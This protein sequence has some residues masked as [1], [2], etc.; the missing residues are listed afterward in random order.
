MVG[1]DL[2]AYGEPQDTRENSLDVSTHNPAQI[3]GADV[4]Y[5][6]PLFQR[7]YVWTKK[8]QWQPLWEDVQA[9]ADRIYI[10]GPPA[11]GAVPVPPHFLGAI[12]LEQ[13][14]IPG[15][16]IATFGVVDGQQRLTTLQLLLDAAQ[17][18][19]EQHGRP[20]DAKA[21]RALVLNDPDIA[22][23]PDDIFKVWPTDRDQAAFR[24]AMKNGESIPPELRDS[25]I[26]AAHAYFVG[27]IDKWAGSTGDP[28]KCKNRLNALVRALREHLQVVRID[29]APEDNAQV[30]FETLNHRGSPLLA[31]DLVKNLLFQ[32]AQNE[33]AD[34]SDLYQ[35]HWRS[36][37][38]DYW[39]K[40]TAQGRRLRPRIDIFLT[41]WLTMKMRREIHNDRVFAEF[42]DFLKTHPGPIVDIVQ[43]LSLHAGVYAKMESL[44]AG[45]VEGDFYYRVISAMDTASVGPVLLWLLKWQAAELPAA[46][47]HRALKAVES[48]LVRRMLCR[49]T[50]KGINLMVLELLKA[51]DEGGPAAAGQLTEELLAS[52]T[53]DARIWPDDA[54]VAQ[55]LASEALYSSLAR[56]RVRLLLEAL[57]DK[58]RAKFAGGQPCPRNLTVEH[59][60]PQGWR[61]YWN[62][63]ALDPLAANTRDSLLHRLGNLSLI[64]GKLNTKLS[65][66]PWTGKI[67]ATFELEPQ[68]KFDYLL[69]HNVLKLNA[70]VVVKHPQSWTDD[71]IRARTQTLSLGILE[72]WPRPAGAA[73]IAP[74]AEREEL[75]DEV[76]AEPKGPLPAAA[77]APEDGPYEPLRHWLKRQT[78]DELSASFSD[79]ED[80]LQVP[81]P[82]AAKEH[83]ALWYADEDSTVGRAVRDAGWLTASVN[84]SE[85]VLRL[86]R[87]P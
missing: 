25:N 61:A 64:E 68:G 37:D 10:A 52:Q 32:R 79:V 3:F 84:L 47:L 6:I 50:G 5:V 33:G 65:N 48:W 38:T 74:T 12:V 9:L 19:T 67:A 16:F 42:R 51:L 14:P 43:E 46:E 36:L 8:D 63:P 22:A 80:I 4:R 44:P 60:L 34:L 41:Y 21:L 78:G 69:A 71:D 17:E 1:W 40:P 27:V 29:L 26:A 39:R 59:I 82:Q 72:L 86:V 31:A 24:A 66:L 53:A 15:G 13:Q 20:I 85:E 73:P 49:L 11:F 18:V 87:R 76:S 7:P 54:A 81:L 62:T 70:E 45:T 75:P 58:R 77:G 23:H 56:A 55:S 2:L 57:E 35:K 83:E 28:D 30:I